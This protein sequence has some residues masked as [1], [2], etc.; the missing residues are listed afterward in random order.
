MVLDSMQ[1]Q[2]SNQRILFINAWNEWAEG[3]VLEPSQRYG[4]GFLRAL[5]TELARPIPV[6]VAPLK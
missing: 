6:P 1:D 5:Q 2:P 3:M 4:H